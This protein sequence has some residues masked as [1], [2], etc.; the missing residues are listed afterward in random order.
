MINF[1][2]IYVYY[3]YYQVKPFNKKVQDKCSTR[4]LNQNKPIHNKP[5]KYSRISYLYYNSAFENWI[6]KLS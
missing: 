5:I 3:K 2:N 4:N 1:K 6:L